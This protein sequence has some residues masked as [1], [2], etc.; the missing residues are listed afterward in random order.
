MRTAP[1]P[2]VVNLAEPDVDG[3]DQVGGP[4]KVNTT[5]GP[6]VVNLAEDYGAIDTPAFVK[7]EYWITSARS[8]SGHKVIKSVRREG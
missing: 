2:A 6:D 1:T 8:A 5:G 7:R 3:P 4:D